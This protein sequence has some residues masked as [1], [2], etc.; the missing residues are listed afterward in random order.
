MTLGDNLRTLRI[1]AGYTQEVLAKKLNLS[2]ANVSKYESGAIE[3]NISTMVSISILFSVSV[4][5]LL[6]LTDIAKPIT[7]SPLSPSENQLIDNYRNLNEEG[8]EKLLDHSI[9]LVSSG[10]YIK[11]SLILSKEPS[12]KIAAYGADGTEDTQ[13][14]IEEKTT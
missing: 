6:G 5:F 1:A 14:P 2:K 8:Q 7:P 10:R 11:K 12:Y 13:P 3:P 4:D 9:D